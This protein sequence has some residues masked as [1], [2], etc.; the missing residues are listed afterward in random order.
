MDAVAAFNGKINNDKTMVSDRYAEFCS[1]IVTKSNRYPIK[2]RF[3]LE[4]DGSFGNVEKFS[5]S[6]LRPK[7]PK[8]VRDLHGF[9]ASYHIDGMGKVP[10]SSTSTPRSLDE[11]LGVNALI[12]AMHSGPRDDEY[13]TLQTLYTRAMEIESRKGVLKAKELSSS[14][15]DNAYPSFGGS[16]AAP[17]V[18]TSY[19]KVNVEDYHVLGNVSTDRT[20]SVVLPVKTEW[21][22]RE[23]KYVKPVTEATNLRK[24][25]KKIESIETSVDSGIITSSRTSDGITTSV[26]I[27]TSV[28]TPQALIVHSHESPESH[29]ESVEDIVLDEPLVRAQT[30]RYDRLREMLAEMDQVDYSEDDS[31][32][33]R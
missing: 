2:P 20:T 29:A 28:P 7:A 6:G 1:H 15:A 23:Q 18:S 11:R 21:D 33:Y 9:T 4:A 10:Y 17:N 19:D 12:V 16:G 14:Y 31:F 22:Y 3:I 8:W 13:V 26:M 30:S 25:R 5:T 27:D 24:L 32:D